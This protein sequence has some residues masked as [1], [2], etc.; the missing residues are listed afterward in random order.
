MLG[1]RGILSSQEILPPLVKPISYSGTCAGLGDP[2]PTLNFS[3][4]HLF[5][6]MG[7]L[8]VP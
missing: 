1:Q 8:N 6:L 2:E 5:L 7:I 3:L 4:S